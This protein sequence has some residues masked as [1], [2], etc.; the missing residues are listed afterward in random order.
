MHQSQ[1]KDFNV[2]A[3]RY[4][5][6]KEVL[7]QGIFTTE[8]HAWKLNRGL[9][10]PYFSKGHVLSID[11]VEHHVDNLI[12]QIP[13]DASPVNF[14]KLAFDFT[15]D[16]IT[17]F[18]FG[19]SVNTLSS[20]DPALQKFADTLDSAEDLMGQRARCGFFYPLVKTRSLKKKAKV[21]H[22]FV[23]SCIQDA[24]TALAE[25]NLAKN[26]D[27]KRDTTENATDNF[28]T[29]REDV[30]SDLLTRTSDFKQIRDNLMALIIAGRDTSAA[31]MSMFFYE[32]SRQPAIWD[33]LQ[34]EVISNFGTENRPDVSE[35][36]RLKYLRQV[37]DETLRMYPPL[38]WNPRV[39]VDDICLPTGG[40]PTGDEPLLVRKGTLVAFSAWALHRDKET[41]GPDAETFVP[42][43]WD[44]LSG[45][46]WSHFIPFGGGPRRCIGQEFALNV[47]TFT[48]VR[49]LQKFSGVKN[50]DP[51]PFQEDL[52]ITLASEHGVHLAFTSRED[53]K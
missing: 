41:F 47:A 32:V 40:G 5:P 29:Q 12:A 30:V 8:G 34:Q 16:V 2:S 33:K 6:M 9:L 4:G 28:P 20:T 39:A 3:S 26:H 23:D 35:A 52:G 1:F 22:E 36:R 44:K 14:Q 15:M 42:E 7:G 45:L 10:R 49:L 24:A 48:I 27:S 53:R 13:K 43:R 18:L 19:R 46:D 21:I 25:N 51:T 17:E 50:V 38:A 37:Y 11:K 31:S